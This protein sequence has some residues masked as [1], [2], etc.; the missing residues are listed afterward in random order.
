M[1]A[2]ILLRNDFNA[3]TLR[4]LARTC[5]DNRQIRRLLA[6]AAVYDGMNR[7]QA[8]RIG[9]ILDNS[10]FC[11][12]IHSIGHIRLPECA[13]KQGFHASF[14]DGR[15]IAIKCISGIAHNLTGFGNIAQLLGQVQQSGFVFD[16]LIGSI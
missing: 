15:F 5:Q 7:T 14:I 4:C 12:L 10:G 9:G 2:A 1:P 11:H 3:V 13:L 6:L 8:T 16:D